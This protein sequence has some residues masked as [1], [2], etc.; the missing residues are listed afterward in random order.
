MENTGKD[1]N[2]IEYPP[3]GGESRGSRARAGGRVRARACTCGRAGVHVCPGVCA[4]AGAN[5][6]ERVRARALERRGR[7]SGPA[8]GTLEGESVSGPCV[9]GA[10]CAGLCVGWAWVLGFRGGIGKGSNPACTR[11]PWRRVGGRIRTCG[12]LYQDDTAPGGYGIKVIPGSI[13]T[14]GVR[15]Q[16]DTGVAECRC[17][18]CW[19]CGGSGGW[20]GWRRGRRRRRLQGEG[21][22]FSPFLPLNSG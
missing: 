14:S 2:I 16:S 22:T 3:L 10:G 17:W 5:L 21:Q 11:I 18:G 4:C 13:R 8:G 7:V 12:V 15:Y 6:G 1:I 20:A 9:S 19:G